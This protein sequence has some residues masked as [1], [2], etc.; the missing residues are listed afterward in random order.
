MFHSTWH[1]ILLSVVALLRRFH[2]AQEIRKRDKTRALYS[3][4]A[5]KTVRHFTP[6]ASFGQSILTIGRAACAAVL[7]Y[8]ASQ[9][10]LSDST[11]TIK[12]LITQIGSA[13]NIHSLCLLLVV[14]SW[15]IICSIIV[16]Q[17]FSILPLGR[18][19]RIVAL[20]TAVVET[21]N[22][23]G[24][25]NESNRSYDRQLNST[26]VHSTLQMAS[27]WGFSILN[28]ICQYSGEYR[29]ILSNQTTKEATPVLRQSSKS[30]RIVFLTIGTR[31]DVQPFVALGKALLK[32]G[33]QPVITT[34]NNFQQF[35]ED[36]GI[37]FQYCGTEMDQPGLLG[38]AADGTNVYIWFKEALK[39]ITSSLYITVNTHMYESCI[40]CDMI[41]STGHTVGQAMDFA[42]KL[43]CLHWCCRLTPHEWFT[44]SFG[45]HSQRGTSFCGCINLMNHYKY[46][47]DIGRAYD[48]AKIAKFQHE[49]RSKKLKLVPSDPGKYD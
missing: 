41:V 43:K 22:Y 6:Q 17:W 1:H 15:T 38:K 36:N 2:L 23:L 3:S 37:E 20:L 31:G 16:E 4:D 19:V 10:L 32:A 8:C 18:S 49:F 7:T 11:F 14:L 28:L 24:I 9:T 26:V 27:V 21:H 45:A 12:S 35:I 5:A 33:H 42:E 34:H 25:K 44:R 29:H 13:N 47:L 30:L 46:W 48:E 39:K 40:G